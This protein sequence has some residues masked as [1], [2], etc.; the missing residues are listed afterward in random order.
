LIAVIPAFIR[1]KFVEIN[2]RA[3]RESR[4]ISKIVVIHDGL[5][6]QA[7][8]ELTNTH[9][10]AREYIEDLVTRFKNAELVKF[11]DNVGA[12]RHMFR[13][14]EMF[15]DLSDKIVVCEE[16]KIPTESGMEYLSSRNIANWDSNLF[17]TLPL[18]YSTNHKVLERKTLLTDN[19]NMIIGR[20]VLELARDLYFGNKKYEQDLDL[21]LKRYLNTIEISLNAK[22]RALNYLTKFFEWSLLSPSRPDSLLTYALLIM[23]N[24]RTSSDVRLSSPISHLSKLGANVNYEL[25]GVNTNCKGDLIYCLEG[26]GL[27]CITC[28]KASLNTR[29]KLKLL[30][31]A[32]HSWTFR[33]NKFL[34]R[35]KGF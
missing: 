4:Y 35:M 31:A 29:V 15:R 5:P 9:G 3:L 32:K 25:T 2:L 7:S 14:Q 11:A 6:T 8:K 17:E 16:D 21:N 1:H 22:A 18:S 33:T 26:R 23:G 27:M 24:L 13:Y 10:F 20:G 34:K 19:G 30:G 12:T 28:E